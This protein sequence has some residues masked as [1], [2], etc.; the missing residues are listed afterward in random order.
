MHWNAEKVHWNSI[1]LEASRASFIWIIKPLLD[2]AGVSRKGDFPE[3]RCQFNRCKPHLLSIRRIL[4]FFLLWWH[5]AF[6]G[7]REAQYPISRQHCSVATAEQPLHSPF[8]GGAGLG[9]L[10]NDIPDK[11]K[12]VWSEQRI[13]KTGKQTWKETSQETGQTHNHHLSWF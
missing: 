10:G 6:N 5:L 13:H 11:A 9:K 2:Q 8:P 1:K 4:P 7:T 3:L 12:S